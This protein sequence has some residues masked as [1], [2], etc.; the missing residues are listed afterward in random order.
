MMEAQQSRTWF[1]VAAVAL[2]SPALALAFFS[3]FFVTFVSEVHRYV[4]CAVLTVFGVGATLVEQRIGGRVGRRLGIT[5][6]VSPCAAALL[7]AVWEDAVQLAAA[8]DGASR[9]S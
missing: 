5:M 3:F 6:M 7:I 8:A 4:I 1:E 9:R 2:G